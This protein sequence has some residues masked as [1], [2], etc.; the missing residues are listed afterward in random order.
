M[1]LFEAFAKRHSYRFDYTDAPV[2]REDLTKILNAALKAP[3]G[4]N[5]QTTNFVIV[6]DPDTCAKIGSLHASN[7]AVCQAKA[8]IVC[9]VD[10]E[11]EAIYEGHS[12]QIEDCAAAVENMLLAITSLGYASVWVDGWLR[13]NAH[14]QTIAQMLSV[15]DD[16]VIRVIL[17][18]GVPA[19]Q[20]AQPEKKTF[21]QR[22]WFGKYGG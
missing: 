4:K 9:I 22:A 13:V 21:D 20:K 18:I 14:A 17:P 8:F 5:E 12:F 10:K 1:E 3:S 7:K 15:P 19:Q 16:K 11:A 2:S 6:D